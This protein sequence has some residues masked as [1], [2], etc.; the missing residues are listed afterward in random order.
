MMA[1]DLTLTARVENTREQ[2]T[3]PTQ[4]DL[5]QIKAHFDESIR[6]VEQQY[7]I[8][9]GLFREGKVEESKTILRS[10]IV[11][12]EGILDFLIHE[13][14]KYGLYHMYEGN[15]EKS[16][17]YLNFQI[18][19]KQ[20]EIA[21]NSPDSNEWFFEF[22]N[23]R[24]AR[25][26]FLAENNMNDQLNLIGVP[27]CDVMETAFPMEN[28]QQSVETGRRIIK[29]LFARRNAIAHQNDRSNASAVQTDI[30]KQYVQ[31]RLGEIKAIGNAI[32]TVASQKEA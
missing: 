32:Y 22:L 10:Q 25:D 2:R 28:Q 1:R 18:K 30:T 21:I 4:F 17:K 6:A 13:M 7:E 23:D 20:L 11:L 29:D 9:D 5:N 12:A 27:F 24:F 26:V 8:S 15:W 19:M 3:P 16:E 14:S 31:D